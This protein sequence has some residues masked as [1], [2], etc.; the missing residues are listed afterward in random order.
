MLADVEYQIELLEQ[1]RDLGHTIVHVDMDKF[2]CAV[3]E[4]DE[5]QYR[6]KPM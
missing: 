4:R 5:P 1:A 3:E 2:Y 6:G